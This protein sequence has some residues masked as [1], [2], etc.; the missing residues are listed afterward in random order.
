[1]LTVLSPD[2]DAIA[3][4]MPNTIN[5]LTT[6]YNKIPTIVAKVYLKKSFIK[7]MF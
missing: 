1:M 3:P 7:F 6:E 4:I 2:A 5:K